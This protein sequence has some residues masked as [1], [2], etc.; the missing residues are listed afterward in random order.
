MQSNGFLWSLRIRKKNRK[1]KLALQWM[2]GKGGKNKY[3]C[4]LRLRMNE[5]NAKIKW[6]A[7]VTKSLALR[8]SL[9]RREGRRAEGGVA[10]TS[11]I[12]NVMN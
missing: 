6:K 12:Q 11:G 1:R 7:S 4:E 5:Q 9:E 2:N 3:E 10:G 8:I